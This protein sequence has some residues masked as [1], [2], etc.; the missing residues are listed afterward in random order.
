MLV[1]E[2]LYNF[3]SI[4]LVNYFGLNYSKSILKDVLYKIYL[5]KRIFK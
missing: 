2:D 5:S 4:E 1:S 3:S